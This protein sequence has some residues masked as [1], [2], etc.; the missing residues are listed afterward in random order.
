MTAQSNLTVESGVYIFKD[1]IL[2][3][4]RPYTLSPAK[5]HLSEYIYDVSL[6]EDIIYKKKTG[7]SKGIGSQI[8][9]YRIFERL[10]FRTTK[11][12]GHER[13]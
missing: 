13:W 5:M 3:L 8:K 1:R 11:V 6:G 10:G 7:E 4:R 9:I 12:N 2:Y